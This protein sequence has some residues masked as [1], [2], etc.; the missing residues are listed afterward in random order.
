[1]TGFTVVRWNDY[2]HAL[3]DRIKA[4]HSD[5]NA[6]A[7]CTWAQAEG[8]VAWYNLLNTTRK[9]PGSW[10]FNPVPVQSYPNLAE[11][12]EATALTLEQTGPGVGDHTKILNHLKNNAT[13]KATLTVIGK[14]DWGS[15]LDLLLRVLADVRNDYW[16]Y[17]H[18][19][20]CPT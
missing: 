12:I 8:N 5:H 20:V 4:P 16:T 18:K 1:M 10:D 17:G 6:R 14:S 2:F 3:L 11:G 19:H 7:L 13:A 15:D 9:M